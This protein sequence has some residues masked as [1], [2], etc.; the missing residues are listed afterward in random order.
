MSKLSKSKK[1][2]YH[3]VFSDKEARALKI[4]LNAL[5]KDFAKVMGSNPKVVN[6]L[7]TDNSNLEIVIVNRASGATKIPSNKRKSLDG[8]E[9]HRVYADTD[10]NRIYLEGFDLRGTIYAIYTF[11]EK[12]LGVPPLHY[13]SSWVPVKKDKIVV[14]GNTDIFFKSPQVRY[15]SILPGDQ[16]FLIPGKRNRKSITTFGSKPYF[17]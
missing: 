7:S 11:S 3:I 10:A 9:S 14:P 2:N 4:A 12:F 15:R 6:E 17:G 1:N 13:W 5:K 16:D 8:F